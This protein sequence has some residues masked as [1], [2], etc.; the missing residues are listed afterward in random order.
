MRYTIQIDKKNLSAKIDLPA[1]KSIS[2]RVMIIHA[3]SYSPYRAANLSDSDDTR[4]MEQVMHSN[5]SQFDIGHAGTAMR[6]LTAFLSKIAGQ[7]ILTGSARMKQRPIGILV[8]ALQKL[9]AKIEYLEKEGFPPLRIGGT[10]LKGGTLEMDGSVSSQYIT[11]LLLIAPT[12]DHGLTLKLLDPILSKPYIQLTLGLMSKYGITW[13]WE[14]NVI[15]VPEQNYRVQ[16]FSIESDWSAASYWYEAAAL[17]DTAKLELMHLELPSLQGDSCIARWFEDFDIKTISKTDGIRIVKQ[18]NRHP[19][20]I[21]RDFSGN[22]DMTQTLAVLCVAKKIPFH[23]TG[24]ETLKIKETDRIDALKKELSKFGALLT[25]PKNGELAWNGQIQHSRVQ[26]N[27][28][29]ETY[30]D[31]R[32][33]LAFAPLALA[34]FSLQ[35]ENPR[36]VTKSYPHYWEDLRKAG[37]LIAE[38]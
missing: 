16:P 18:G 21:T 12:L 27:P 38:E 20:K 17:A 7:W 9:G 5:C 28:V 13:H 4:I 35:I 23:F 14:G 11:A 24:V 2:N 26:K 10:H 6:F 34:G 22:P 15:R 1:S 36:V 25:E 8:D 31:H 32:M 33:A 29:I 3:L 30:N 19:Q 37:F